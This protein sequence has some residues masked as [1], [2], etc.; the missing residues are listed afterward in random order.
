MAEK[1]KR[2]VLLLIAGI[3]GIL[4]VI[5]SISYWGGAISGTEDA[6]EAIGAGIATVLVMPHL[7]CTG[8]AVIFNV[9]AWAMRSRPFALVSGILYAVAMVL[10]FMYFM[11]VIVEMILC[12][13]AFA[14]MKKAPEVK[15]VEQ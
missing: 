10:F 1:K 6:A 2:S 15:A 12:F 9:L 7:V 14:R 3:I 13:V 4:Y 8:I 11:F 5:Y